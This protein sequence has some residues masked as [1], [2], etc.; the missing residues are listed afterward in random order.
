[1]PVEGEP[2]SRS[3]RSWYRPLQAVNPAKGIVAATL[4]VIESGIL[5]ALF[6]GILEY[7]ANAPVPDS[8]NAPIHNE[9][10]YHISHHP[11]IRMVDCVNKMARIE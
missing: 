3:L 7:S 6:A 1:M 11:R 5:I 8:I 9:A 10:T 2:G 4:N